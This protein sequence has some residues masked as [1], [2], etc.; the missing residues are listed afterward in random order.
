[1]KN[2]NLLTSD[3]GYDVWQKAIHEKYDS[4]EV[5]DL[6]RRLHFNAGMRYALSLNYEDLNALRWNNYWSSDVKDLSDEIFEVSNDS[7]HESLE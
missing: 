4:K 7:D 2:K 1:M 6:N 5:E 3:N